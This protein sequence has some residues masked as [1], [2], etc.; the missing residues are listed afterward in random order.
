[1]NQQYHDSN[2]NHHTTTVPVSRFFLQTSKGEMIS[3]FNKLHDTILH[4]NY[5]YEGIPKNPMSQ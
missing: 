2:I 5:L 3:S 4:I 1:M